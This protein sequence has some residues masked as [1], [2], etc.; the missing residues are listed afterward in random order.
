MDAVPPC[1]RTFAYP[2]EEKYGALWIF[3]GPRPLF[4]VPFFAGWREEELLGV[5]LR[6]Q[7]LNCHPHVI[8]CNGLDI[9]H[10]KTV[11]QLAFVDEPVAEALDAY[12]MQLKLHIRLTGKNLFAKALR[13]LG[14]ET[15]AATFTTWGGNLATIDGRLGAYQ[16]LVLFT[17]RPLPD[18]KSASQ[19]FL[20]V[21]RGHRLRRLPGINAFFGMVV[22]CIMGYILV[23]DRKLL[24]TLRFRANFVGA[25]APLV[26]FINQVERMQV[27]EAPQ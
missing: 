8:A 14:G 27:F 25:D 22:K 24:D 26:A 11:H 17:H 4:P 3:N 20:F 23:Q 12:R 13:C 9:Q 7:V 18:G 2:T 19:T 10:F 16:I 15:V 5:P 1:T 21:P 6:P